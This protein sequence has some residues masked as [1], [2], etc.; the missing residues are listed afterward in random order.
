MSLF[1]LRQV[2]KRLFLSAPGTKRR[3]SW[4]RLYVEP[5]EMRVVPSF[6]S[7]GSTFGTG[8]M[9]LAVVVADVN[10][11]GKPDLV[12]ANEGSNSVSVLLGNWNGTFA[13][14]QN[15][16]TGTAPYA[17]AMADLNGD[18]KVDVVVANEG[19]NTVS[20]L[21]GNGTFAAAQSFATGKAPRTMV[22]A[23]INGDGRFD[24]VTASKGSNT[25]SVLL[26]NRNAATQFQVTAPSS[27]TAGVPFKITVTALTAGNGID[28]LY[29]GTV[30][31]TSSDGMAVLPHN[32]TFT[33]RDGGIHTF[34]VTLNTTGTQTVTTTDTVTNTIT[35][36]AG[37]MVNAAGA[38]P[39]Q[40][41]SGPERAASDSADGTANRG[42]AVAALLAAGGFGQSAAAHASSGEPNPVSA[43][44]TNRL[45]PA[46]PVGVAADAFAVPG[47][48]WE[49]SRGTAGLRLAEVE[50]LFAADT[51]NCSPTGLHPRG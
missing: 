14:A 22:V 13:A 8:T 5:L 24:V 18:G 38:P 26:G 21:L 20:V 10:R 36:S 34:T 1:W 7:A 42:S 31:F 32:Y 12:I 46:V 23:D 15:F 16:A 6:F 40:A 33:K 11:D 48:P 51:F 41:D 25:V 29:T 45:A 19:G 39:P 47:P 43:P 9:P 50:A 44:Q 2:H 17:V 3:T 37:V 30:T 28:C 35:G 27:V 49:E 4:A